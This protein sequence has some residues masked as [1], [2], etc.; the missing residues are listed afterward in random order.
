MSKEW[1]DARIQMTSEPFEAWWLEFYGKPEAY[2][3][4][5]D[6]QDEYWV[7][8]GFAWHGWTGHAGQIQT[9]LGVVA[10][11]LTGVFRAGDIV[12]HGPTGE[13]WT[14]AWADGD[15][16]SA[17]GWPES[18]AKAADCA[19]VQRATE[20]ESLLILEKWA[21]MAPDPREG[22]D[23]RTIKAKQILEQM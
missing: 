10:A 1:F 12:M 18:I 11:T 17:E 8:K 20:D 15:E 3:N 19:L 9:A 2:E 16:V 4:N 7:R 21:N 13:K 22:T 5:H 14:L 6:E 23:Y